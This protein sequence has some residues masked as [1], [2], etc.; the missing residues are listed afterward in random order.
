M[1][2]S[3]RSI[4]NEIFVALAAISMLAL[5]VVF[6]IVLTADSAQVVVVTQTPSTATVIS[7]GPTAATETPPPPTDL[8]S[9]TD[10][11]TDEP[12]AEPSA[13]D[14]PT[15]APS[16]T[17]P[18][19][20]AAPE[21]A[22][23]VATEAASPTTRPS[24]TPRPTREP[25]ATPA[26]SDTPLPSP[27]PTTADTTAPPQ[28]STAVGLAI[29]PVT[30]QPGTCAP[31]EGWQPYVIQPYDNLFRL[32]L[33][34]GLSAEAVQEANCLPSA[35]NI[36]SGN[37][38]YLPPVFFTTSPSTNP[39]V[40]P[41]PG[42]PPVTSGGVPD[43]QTGT[44]YPLRL[45][46]LLTQIQITSPEAGSTQNN[47]F[48]V[49]GTATLANEAN[50]E[51]YK[52]DIRGPDGILRNVNQSSTAVYGPGAPLS[53]IDPSAFAPGEYQIILTVVDRTGNF[54]EPCAIRVNLR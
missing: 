5:A 29:T 9:P 38:I 21:E 53:V 49:R 52:I 47:R 25:S 33:R 2:T 6:A 40:P 51:Y 30:S 22:A 48:T 17:P 7:M 11:A 15:E 54:P 18:P 43:L 34:A 14:E 31:P 13:T 32:G 16:D 20:D 19:T 41:A 10:T 50:F 3:R 35:T 4:R 24:R 23:E 44:L 37:V 26:A 39:N 46:C 12:T 42:Q 45:G 27:T 28:A 1:N 36:T 8:P